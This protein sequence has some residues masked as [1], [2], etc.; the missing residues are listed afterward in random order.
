MATLADEPLMI[1]QTLSPHRETNGDHC[2]DR[3]MRFGS[4]RSPRAIGIADLSKRSL[5]KLGHSAAA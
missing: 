5:A 3:S 2:D 4:P 1:K